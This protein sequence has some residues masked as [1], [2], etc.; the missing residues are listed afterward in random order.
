MKG[1]RLG[2]ALFGLKKEVGYLAATEEVATREGAIKI[3][4]KRARPG[5]RLETPS[6]RLHRK[7][8]PWDRKT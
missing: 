4:D 6:A 1:S 7:G 3:P 2:G 5:K 8:L